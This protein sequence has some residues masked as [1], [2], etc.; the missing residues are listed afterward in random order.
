M[1]QMPRVGTHANGLRKAGKMRGMRRTSPDEGLHKGK[2]F[3]RELRQGTQ[4]MAKTSLL[5]LPGLPRR[6]EEKENRP[7]YANGNRKEHN[8]RTDQPPNPNNVPDPSK[9]T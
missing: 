3:L 1:L 2:D 6:H 5:Y 8:Q 4:S 7:D 9:K